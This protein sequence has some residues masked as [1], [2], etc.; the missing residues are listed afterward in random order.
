MFGLVEEHLPFTRE[1]RVRFPGQVIPK[2]SKMERTAIVHG[3]QHKQWSM[4]NKPVNISTMSEYA[5]QP[6]SNYE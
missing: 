3:A 1:S 5:K 2:T 4:Q 6:E